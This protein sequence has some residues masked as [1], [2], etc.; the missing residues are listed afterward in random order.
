MLLD[1]YLQS[2]ESH[3]DKASA[4][5]DEILSR[6]T[7]DSE[8]WLIAGRLRM[9]KREYQAAAERFLRAAQLKPDWAEAHI[10]L[11]SA[12][13][14]LKQYEPTLRVLAKVAELGQDT[15]G[16]HFLRAVSH[17]HLRHQEEAVESYERFLALTDGKNQNQEFQARQRVR[18]ISNDLRR[19]GRG[20]R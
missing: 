8:L 9:E 11:A 3:Q 4:L 12:L 14:L 17:D 6:N 7:S 2:Q 16:S 20:R 18:I 19:R 5:L 10:N 13:F 15:A 1:A